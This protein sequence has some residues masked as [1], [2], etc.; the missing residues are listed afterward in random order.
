M[1]ITISQDV[2]LS[3]KLRYSKYNSPSVPILIWIDDE[4]T[5][6]ATF[7]PEDQGDWN[8]F[9]WTEPI[10]LGSV[11]GGVHSL[12]FSSD[13]QPYGVAELDKFVLSAVPRPEAPVPTPETPAEIPAPAPTEAPYTG[14]ERIFFTVGDT[15]Y[16]MNLDGSG[17]TS[18]VQGLGIVEFL[19]VDVAHNKLI[20]T[21]QDRR[22]IYVLDLPGA[23]NL[24]EFSDIPGS[25]GQG[26]AIDPSGRTMFLGLYYD[27]VYVRDMNA[28]GYWQQ[29]I[30][31]DL[32][33]VRVA[34]QSIERI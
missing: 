20:L 14:S 27:G 31:S 28:E 9:A 19:T 25:N 5:P 16:Q 10:L 18:L 32:P 29:L 34:L 3:L 13:G 21:N 6:R 24:R 30:S 33:Q 8:R 23:K 1:N 22:K 11:E 12:I 15:L 17:L 2:T 26:L 4:P 7:Y